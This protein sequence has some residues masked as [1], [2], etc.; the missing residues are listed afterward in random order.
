MITIGVDDLE[1][2]MAIARIPVSVIPWAAGMLGLLSQE[3]KSF[4]G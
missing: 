1:R 4:G 2:A 3:L